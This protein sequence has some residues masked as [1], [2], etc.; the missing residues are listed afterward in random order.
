MP[1]VNEQLNI[2]RVGENWPQ[3]VDLRYRDDVEQKR[4]FPLTK[5]MTTD[6]YTSFSRVHTA[7][8]CFDSVGSATGRASGL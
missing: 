7:L 1:K 2:I 4:N 6:S 8:Q 3:H 5:L